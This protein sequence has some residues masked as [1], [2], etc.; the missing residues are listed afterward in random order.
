MKHFYMSMLAF[1]LLGTAQLNAQTG[2]NLLGAKGTFSAP[3]VT[4]NTTASSCTNNGSNS[5]SPVDNIGNSL[6]TLSGIGTA[7]PGSGYD[8]TAS[9][10]GL[11]PEFTYTLIKNIGDAN[12]GNCIKGDWRGQNH[13]PDDGWFMAVN[14]APNN[15]KSPIFYKIDAISVCPGT[16]YEFSAWVINMLPKSSPA[17]IAGSEPNISFKV[18]SSEGSSIVASSGPIAYTNTPT[19]VKVSGTFTVPSTI[20]SIDLEVINATSIASGNDLGLDDI[21]LNVEKSNIVLSGVN[22]PLT[23]ALCDGNNTSVL[24]TVNDDTQTNAWYKWQVSKDGGAT[25]SDSTAPAQATFSGNSYALTLNLT[26]VSTEMSGFK[27]RLVVSTSQAGLL[28]PECTYVNEYTLMVNACAPTPVIMTSFNGKYSNGQV[29]LDWQTSQ[30]FNSDRFEVYKSNDGQSFSYLGSVKGAGNSN[31]TKNY[32][33]FDNQP[34]G[35]QYVY[36]RLKQVD[37]D[38]KFVYTNVVKITT[39]TNASLEVYPNPFSSYFT[40]SFTANKTADASIIVRN[41][42]G[43][44]VMQRSIKTVKGSN[45]VNVNNLSSLKAG[46]YYVT[47]SNDDINY[48]IKLQKQ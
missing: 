47:I 7:Q 24:F 19:W 35:S 40:A 23:T 17:A 21:S 3:F 43:Q 30:E 4:P 13:T 38:G 33:Y 31:M 14:G 15:T 26:H 12:G 41:S 5:Y 29:V 28:N 45:S 6:N 39:G 44:P 37:I 42:I 11:T 46:I 1:A 8:Y 16:K 20:S 25:Y 22:G 36:Y 32:N 18:T 34:G 9:S 27:Y 10:G 2:P 48:N